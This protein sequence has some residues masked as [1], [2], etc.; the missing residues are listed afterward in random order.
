[1]GAPISSLC[2]FPRQVMVDQLRQK[3]WLFALS[4]TSLIDTR[5]QTINCSL[6]QLFR[7]IFV[8][9]ADDRFYR[10]RTEHSQTRAEFRHVS[11][12]QK[13]T[14]R[15]SRV[16]LRALMGASGM[17]SKP[18]EIQKPTVVAGTDLSNL[19]ILNK[20]TAFTEAERKQ[21][22]MLP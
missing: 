22:I 12:D 5:S 6:G 8:D 17:A 11:V 16:R 2:Q 4:I 21:P 1:M 15:S 20:G 7:R 10:A 13:R 14:V 19:P 3:D 9:R 18:G